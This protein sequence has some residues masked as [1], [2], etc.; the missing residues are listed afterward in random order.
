MFVLMFPTFVE[1]SS[2]RKRMYAV[3]FSWDDYSFRDRPSMDN[4]SLFWLMSEASLVARPLLYFLI[5]LYDV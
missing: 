4:K 5:F 1:Y 3:N 2:Y